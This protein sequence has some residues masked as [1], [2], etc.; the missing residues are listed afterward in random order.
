MAGWPFRRFTAPDDRGASYQIGFRSGHAAGELLLRPDPPH[1][2]RWLDLITAPGEPATRIDLLSWRYTAAHRVSAD[3]PFTDAWSAGFVNPIRM[4][5]Q[6]R[7]VPADQGKARSRTGS[8][9]L[10][11]A[12]SRPPVDADRCRKADTRVSAR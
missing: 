5:G 3:D 9:R 1:Q 6:A 7:S 2:I 4:F 11:L 10:P 8:S 12:S